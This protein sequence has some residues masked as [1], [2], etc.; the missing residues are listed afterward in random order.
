VVALTVDHYDTTDD[1]TV[2]AAW[3]VIDA[4][5]AHDVP[6]VPPMTFERYAH[7]ARHPRRRLQDGAVPGRQDGAI[8]GVGGAYLAMHGNIHVADVLIRVHPAARRRGAGRA[9]LDALAAAARTEGR[10][11]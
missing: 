10:R 5:A 1:A 2:R 8:V 4:V 6:D 7:G 3:A 9:V 11:V